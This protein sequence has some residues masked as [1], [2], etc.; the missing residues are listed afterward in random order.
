MNTCIHTHTHTYV[1]IHVYAP[2][3]NITYSDECWK[4]SIRVIP[5][6]Y[7]YIPLSVPLF[8]ARTHVSIYVDMRKAY[9]CMYVCMYVCTDTH[10]DVCICCN[11]CIYIICL[12]TLVCIRSFV[13]NVMYV[14]M[15]IHCSHLSCLSLSLSHIHTQHTYTYTHTHT[16]NTQAHTYTH[17]G[18]YPYRCTLLRMCSTSMYIGSVQRIR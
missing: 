9:V 2:S 3:G 13:C 10:V 16:H 14:C 8:C 6:P 17:T 7:S 18:G 5:L 1:Y 12:C 4:Q 11:V 15:Y